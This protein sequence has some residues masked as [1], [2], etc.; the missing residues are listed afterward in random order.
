MCGRFGRHGGFGGY[1]VGLVGLVGL[2]CCEGMLYYG[3]LILRGWLV[4]YVWCETAIGL[5]L[6]RLAMCGSLR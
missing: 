4:Y 3:G 2:R 1:V 6:V 5:G